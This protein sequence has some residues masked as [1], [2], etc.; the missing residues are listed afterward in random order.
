MECR[1]P[2]DPCAPG[3]GKYKSLRE[4]VREY[5]ACKRSCKKDERDYFRGLSL[6]KA[7]ESAALAKNSEGKRSGHH[8]RRTPAQLAQGKA[9]LIALF[10]QIRSCESFDQLHK[11]VCE[12]TDPIK[13]LGELY[14]YDTAHV[15][16]VR[17]C[18]RPKKVYLHAGTR[19]GAQALGFPGNLPHLEPSQLPTELQLLKPCKM[20]D[21]LCIYEAAFR[22]LGRSS[23]R[24]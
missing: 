5:I 16:G 17:L 23:R 6:E 1:P 9:K 13:G 7:I 19:K 4:M 21:F 2:K 20:E 3:K 18:L 15:I 22:K 8:R 10:S 12:A 11:L 14:A 24:S